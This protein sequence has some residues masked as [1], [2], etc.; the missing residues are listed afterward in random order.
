MLYGAPGLLHVEIEEQP[1]HWTLK[2]V[3]D[4]PGLPEEDRER[5]RKPF[6]PRSGNR[7]GG[8]LGLSIVEEVMQAHGGHMAFERDG[9]NNFVVALRFKK[10]AQ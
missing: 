2:F 4:G 1:E 10:I 8:S 6:A 5:V 9:A 7:S 3:D